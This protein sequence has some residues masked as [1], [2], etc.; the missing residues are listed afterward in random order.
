MLGLKVTVLSFYFHLVTSDGAVRFFTEARVARLTGNLVNLAKLAVKAYLYYK[1]RRLFHFARVGGKSSLVAN[2]EK[3][4]TNKSKNIGLK[5]TIFFF[6]FYIKKK[7]KTNVLK[8]K[9]KFKS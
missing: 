3:Y 5:S 1:N 8:K 7:K 2:Q 6:F 4:E 9:N